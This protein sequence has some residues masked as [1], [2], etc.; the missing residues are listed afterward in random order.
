MLQDVCRLLKVVTFTY[1]PILQG[2]KWVNRRTSPLSL[3]ISRIMAAGGQ[4]RFS[5]TFEFRRELLDALIALCFVSG[6]LIEF[7]RIERIGTRPFRTFR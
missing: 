1:L 5:S 2:Q 6:R 3:K 7:E 4:R